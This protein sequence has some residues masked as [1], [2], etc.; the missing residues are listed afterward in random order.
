MG[1]MSEW[2]EEA[3][4]SDVTEEQLRAG[5]VLAVAALS[6]CRSEVGTSNE[7]ACPLELLPGPRREP[8]AGCFVHATLEAEEEPNDLACCW[9][10]V[11]LGR[12]PDVAE[13]LRVWH[14]GEQVPGKCRAAQCEAGGPLY[15]TLGYR[16]GEPDDRCICSACGREWEL[17]EVQNGGDTD[18]DG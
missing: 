10:T 3:M 13:A 12:E 18:G 8:C 6:E 1:T 5:F 9:V 7:S 2:I 14:I 4:P 16:T 17:S 11:L 15:A